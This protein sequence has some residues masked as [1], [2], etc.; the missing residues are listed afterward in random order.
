MHSQVQPYGPPSQRRI[1]DSIVLGDETASSV[2]TNDFR[3]SSH[4]QHSHASL[5][6][7]GK[8]EDSDESECIETP[9]EQGRIIFDNGLPISL[10]SKRRAS[11]FDRMKD[12][13]SLDGSEN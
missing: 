2:G 10:Q 8:S 7:F 5:D 12:S 3:G 6:S 11:L 1:D 13:S 9:N 4:R